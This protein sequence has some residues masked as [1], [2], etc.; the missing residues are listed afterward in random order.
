MDYTFDIATMAVP[1]A[2]EAIRSYFEK[3][4]DSERADEIITALREQDH[5]YVEKLAADAGARADLQRILADAEANAGV[6][7]AGARER[8][9]Y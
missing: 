4:E 1:V 5:A 9:Y 3:R 7:S 2:T 8:H 6:S